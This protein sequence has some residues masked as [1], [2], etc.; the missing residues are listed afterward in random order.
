MREKAAPENC[1]CS[2]LRGRFQGY[3]DL[4]PPCDKAVNQYVQHD[5]HTLS[6]VGNRSPSHPR[7][8]GRELGSD[9]VPFNPRVSL[10]FLIVEV[11]FP[12]EAS[13]LDDDWDMESGCSCF[14]NVG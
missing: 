6:E 13:E 5:V 2:N 11:D 4:I 1:V 8:H 12:W 7:S 9:V 14:I 3:V 10:R